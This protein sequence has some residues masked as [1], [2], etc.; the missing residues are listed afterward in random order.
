MRPAPPHPYLDPRGPD[1]APL[2]V[3]ALA[4]RGFSYGRSNLENSLAAFGAAVDLGFR[5]VETDAHGTAD[6]VAVALHDASLDRT[7]DAT[8]RVAELPWSVVRHAR[9]GGTEPVPRLD[10][11]LG[12][13]PDLRVNIDV[14]EDSGVGPTA[15]AIERTGAHD[16]VCV[17]SFDVGRRRAT[18][19][20]LSRPVTTSAGRRE[21]VGFLAGARLRADALARRALR[22]VDALQVPVTEGR[23]RVVDAVSVAAAHRAGR[24][25]HVW[26]INTPGEMG[27]LLDLGVD[28]IVTD[29]ADLLRDVLV[30]RG[31]WG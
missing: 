19:A 9:I 30:A 12:T 4:H 13:W 23:V 2:E 29:R 5:Y 7:T 3:V 27:R 15:D 17:T 26:T 10:E 14:K 21:V 1:G 20:R 22:E 6:G 11:V 16:R 18:L 25:V 8:G 28:G 31:L 24:Q